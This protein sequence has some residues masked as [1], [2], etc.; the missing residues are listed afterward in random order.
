MEMVVL[1]LFQLF[2]SEDIKLLPRS[3]SLP[4]LKDRFNFVQ[5]SDWRL[6]AQT[7]GLTMG[8]WFLHC[9]SWGANLSERH[10][11]LPHRSHRLRN[12]MEGSSMR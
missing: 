9:E 11:E 12:E 5:L 2:H 8:N 3:S 10:E 7:S 4:C 1:P 6:I